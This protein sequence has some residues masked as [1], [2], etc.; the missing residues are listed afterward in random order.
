MDVHEK[1][2]PGAGVTPGGK[3]RVEFSQHNLVACSSP[4]FVPA[5]PRPVRLHQKP[6]WSGHGASSSRYEAMV[7]C[8]R[9]PC[10]QM[11]APT[12]IPDEMV[13]NAPSA[14]PL[15]DP[16]PVPLLD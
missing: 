3:S 13:P 10:L 15:P 16:R 2:P 12:P 4:L 14:P 6:P 7:P 11:S 8:Q 5:N 9:K 1:I